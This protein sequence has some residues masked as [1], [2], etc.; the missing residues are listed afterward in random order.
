MY[1][2]HLCF[3]KATY[4]LSHWVCSL[5]CGLCTANRGHRDVTHSE[6]DTMYH[7]MFL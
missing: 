6:A 5:V 7:V 3:S 1:N 2:G 4:S